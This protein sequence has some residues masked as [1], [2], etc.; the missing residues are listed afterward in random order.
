VHERKLNQL[1]KDLPLQGEWGEVSIGGH[2]PKSGKARR[3]PGLE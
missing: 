1:K 3:K 2:V